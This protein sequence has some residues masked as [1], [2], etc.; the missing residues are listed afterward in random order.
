[1]ITIRLVCVGNLKEKFWLE[2]Q[3]EYQKRLS[4][5]C[6]LEIVELEEQNKFDN[7]ERIKTAEGEEIL[8][9]LSGR[10]VLLDVNGKLI[11]SEQF[12]D[13]IENLSLQTS[14][15]TFVIGGSYGVS[16]EVQTKIGDKISFGRA[17]FP[18]NL[19]R[20]ILLEQVYRSFMIKS[21]SK[22]H[23]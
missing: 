12:A 9:A 20:I 6:K 8:S 19:A 16:D 17:T 15:I 11:S 3:K 14:T 1:M 23:K 18:H 13:K 21:N 2:A 5:F 7:I 22:Y 4:R 10:N